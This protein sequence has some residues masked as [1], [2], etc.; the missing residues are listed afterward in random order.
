MATLIRKEPEVLVVT[1]ERAG[2]KPD[3][4]LATGGR[5]ALGHA[6]NLLIAHRELQ[7]GDRLTVTAAD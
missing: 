2:E 7:A 4:R 5:Q 1:F 6:I 3:Q